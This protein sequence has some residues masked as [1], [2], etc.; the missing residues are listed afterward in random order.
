MKKGYNVCTFNTGSLCASAVM[1]KLFENVKVMW[2]IY[3]CLLL[4]SIELF[5]VQ[6]FALLAPFTTNALKIHIFGIQKKDIC[7]DQCVPSYI[8][9]WLQLTNTI[10]DNRLAHYSLAEL[11]FPWNLLH[12]STTYLHG[13][14]PPGWSPARQPNRQPEVDISRVGGWR[15]CVGRAKLSKVECLLQR[16]LLVGSRSQLSGVHRAEQTP[17]GQLECSWAVGVVGLM[18]PPTLRGGWARAEH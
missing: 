2:W 15:G 13:L 1:L 12:L 16:I 9:A 5:Y 6:P 10:G 7:G 18:R 17:S 3:L 8:T 14:H 11:P 4:V